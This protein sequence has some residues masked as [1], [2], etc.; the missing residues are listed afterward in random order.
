LSTRLEA[1]LRREIDNVGP[2]LVHVEP[3]SMAAS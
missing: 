1:R 3:R 2:V